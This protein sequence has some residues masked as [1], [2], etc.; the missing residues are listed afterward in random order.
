MTVTIPMKKGVKDDFDRLNYRFV[1]I[2][3]RNILNPSRPVIL[4][5]ADIF[6]ARALGGF[7]VVFFLKM[8][9][10]KTIIK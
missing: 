1:N 6:F 3:K 5:H 9:R 2:G 8:G 7:W 10:S 4:W